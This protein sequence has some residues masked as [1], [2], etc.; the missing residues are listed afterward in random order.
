M[1][2]MEFSIGAQALEALAEAVTPR[3]EAR[4]GL[5]MPAGV[6]SPY[7]D[8]A[9]CDAY[10]A[11]VRNDTLDRM[12]TMFSEVAANGTLSST[13]LSELLGVPPRKLSSNVT[14]AAKKRAHTLGLPWP[15]VPGNAAGRTVWVDVGGNA[16]RIVQAIKREKTR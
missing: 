15:F 14:N 2:T 9:V 13:R 6:A 16:A 5:T 1:A 7:E 8:D 4:L 10:V 12:E 3:V 11:D